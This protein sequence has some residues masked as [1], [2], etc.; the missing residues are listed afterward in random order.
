[1]RD[2]E[3]YIGLRQPRVTG[4]QYDAFIDE[5]MQVLKSVTYILIYIQ[6]DYRYVELFVKIA[7]VQLTRMR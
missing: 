3:D 1:M 6:T 5:F 4:A 2:D 7:M